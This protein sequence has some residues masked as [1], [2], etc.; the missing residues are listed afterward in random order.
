MSKEYDKNDDLW[1]KIIIL[2]ESEVGKSCVLIRFTKNSFSFLSM[3][4]IGQ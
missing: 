4:T 2:G 3:A 1:M